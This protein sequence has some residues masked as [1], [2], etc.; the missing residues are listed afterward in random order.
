MLPISPFTKMLVIGLAATA[1]MVSVVWTIVAI[2]HSGAV[3]E[4]AEE[5]T[6]SV[7]HARVVS[8]NAQTVDADVA[9]DSDPLADLRKN[10]SK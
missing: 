3:Q 4:R 2:K 5:V 9:K 6:K 1:I 8:K 7:D 10:W